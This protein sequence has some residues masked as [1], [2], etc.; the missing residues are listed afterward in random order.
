M[1]R[2][3]SNKLLQGRIKHSQ[4]AEHSD[5]GYTMESAHIQLNIQIY[6]FRLHYI[7][8]LLCLSFI[9]SLGQ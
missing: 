2:N 5:S 3:S 1:Q 6:S 7:K 9:S 8:L 4:L